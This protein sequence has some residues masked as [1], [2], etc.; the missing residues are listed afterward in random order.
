MWSPSVR[1]YGSDDQPLDTRR[2]PVCEAADSRSGWPSSRNAATTRSQAAARTKSLATART[3][4]LA[5]STRE[6][7]AKTMIP[8][9]KRCRYM[10]ACGV[11]PRSCAPVRSSSGRASRGTQPPAP[12][13]SP[14]GAGNCGSA[15]PPWL[16]R[17]S[18]TSS[19]VATSL[20]HHLADRRGR[21]IPLLHHDPFHQVALAEN[22]AQL[23]PLQY[24]D[25]PDV[26]FRH[27]SAP[28]RPRS[29]S[30]TLKS[31]RFWTISHYSG[32]ITLP[33]GWV[34]EYHKYT[35]CN[36]DR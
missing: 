24:Q 29:C 25:G 10:P 30:S 32:H 5:D 20:R 16:L 34:A 22:P 21:G 12:R 8:V 36:Q 31:S 26:E 2:P 23:D 7:W 28:L 14:A 11:I 33:I 9:I 35:P 15:L 13:T 19:M 4:S 18:P 3:A 1:K 6:P 17:C 27:S